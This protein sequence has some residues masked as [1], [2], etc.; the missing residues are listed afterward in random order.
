VIS[1]GS[2]CRSSRT[3]E[4]ENVTDLTLLSRK[5]LYTGK[6]FD[7]IVD[8]IQY[9]SGN[10]GIREIARHPGGA[11]T[12]PLLEDGNV[13]FVRQYRYPLQRKLT[14]LPAGKISPGENPDAAA[15]R[16]LTE[17]TGYVA[18]SLEHLVTI[19]SSP[20][21]CDEQ[22]FVYLARDLSSR[23][24]GPAREEGEAAMTLETMPLS[25]AIGKVFRGEFQD[26]KTIVGLLLA[27]ARV[28]NDSA[29]GK[30]SG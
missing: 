26:A 23:P 20:G 14:E 2:V 16:E 7:L 25:V 9:P 5:V 30:R 13:V 1:A 10:H 18:G 3:Q 8:N 28:K 6:V 21:F 12:V 27:D 11:V 29:R 15:L 19:Y 17:E 4:R 22:L 24:G